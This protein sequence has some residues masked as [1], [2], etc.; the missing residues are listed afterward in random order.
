MASSY[1]PID[2]IW[3]STSYDPYYYI[4]LVDSDDQIA[5]VSYFWPNQNLPQ[6]KWY[7]AL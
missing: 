4:A 1:I 6:F 3:Y 5:A 7:I 2:A